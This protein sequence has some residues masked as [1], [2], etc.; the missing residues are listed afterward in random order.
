MRI[1]IWTL[2]K[3]RL[4]YTK[5]CSYALLKSGHGGVEHLFIDNGSQDGTVQWLDA[6]CGNNFHKIINNENKGISAG[7]R[8]AFFYF[9]AQGFMPEDMIIKMDN[10]CEIKTDGLIN[11]LIKFNKLV[12]PGVIAVPRCTGVKGYDS[13]E[14][15]LFP[16]FTFTRTDQVGGIFWP[17]RLFEMEWIIHS[18]IR[19]R[20]SM[21]CNLMR[22]MG[23]KVGFI[24]NLMV[25]HM[26]TTAGQGKKYPEYFADER[27]WY[28]Y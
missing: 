5:R 21:N 13:I 28:R 16:P 4:D 7:W 22:K 11:K 3:D 9:K 6:Q 2:T 1:G 27:P 18:A 14:S 8:Q 19:H 15:E 25:H 26:D 17:C 20:D 23:Y 12:G 10:D 24:D